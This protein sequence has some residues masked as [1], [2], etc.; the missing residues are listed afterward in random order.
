MGDTL[1]KLKAKAQREAD[2]AIE[3][4]KRKRA[5]ENRL[6][7]AEKARKHAT[8]I[9]LGYTLLDEMEERAGINSMVREIL[10][11]RLTVNRDRNLFELKPLAEEQLKAPEKLE[12]PTMKLVKDDAA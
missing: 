7:Q 10:D 1:E 8:A 12:I 4:E 3:A 6:R 9:V 2:K 11:R 5:A